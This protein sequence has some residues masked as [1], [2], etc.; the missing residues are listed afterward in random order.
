MISFIFN[1]HIYPLHTFHVIFDQSKLFFVIFL[2]NKFIF[3][4]FL[5]ISYNKQRAFLPA[6]CLIINSVFKYDLKLSV[7]SMQKRHTAVLMYR[8]APEIFNREIQKSGQD[9]ADG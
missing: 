7:L 4:N 3:V 6:A 5:T 9:S 1:K 8:S 2:T